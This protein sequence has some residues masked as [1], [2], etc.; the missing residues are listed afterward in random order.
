[1]NAKT[2]GWESYTDR[3]GR[4]HWRFPATD[5]PLES[6]GP[7][8]RLRRHQNVGTLLPVRARRAP[9]DFGGAR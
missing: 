3:S 9:A 8:V 4:R 2:D 6:A 7:P 1:L 5:R